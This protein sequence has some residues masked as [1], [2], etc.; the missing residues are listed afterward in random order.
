MTPAIDERDRIRAACPA[1]HTAQEPVQQRGQERP[2]TRGEPHPIP[3]ELAFQHRRDRG[4][5]GRVC[6]R[7]TGN[8]VADRGNAHR[9][10]NFS[11][12]IFRIVFLRRSTLYF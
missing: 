1:Q 10:P 4:S 8:G 2:V 7:D 12:L 6:E 3:A 9:F 5:R 11:Q